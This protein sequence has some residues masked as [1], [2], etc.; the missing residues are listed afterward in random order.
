MWTTVARSGWAA[1]A[2]SRLQAAATRGLSRFVGRDSE[3]EQLGRALKQA[4]QGRGQVVAVVGE[5]GVGK[6]RLFH[7]FVHSHR[8]T[9]WLVLLASSVSYGR[10]TSYLPVVDLLK[11]YFEVEDGDCRS[12]TAYP[13]LAGGS[14]AI[15]NNGANAIVCSSQTARRWHSGRHR[16]RRER[17]QRPRSRC[18]RSWAPISPIACAR[19]TRSG[20]R[21][22]RDKCESLARHSNF[23]HGAADRPE[24]DGGALNER[25]TLSV[26]PHD[27]DTRGVGRDIESTLLE[28]LECRLVIEHDQLLI[29][30]STD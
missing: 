29:G 2:R 30:L 5:L 20:P 7:E 4:Q 25:D 26:A 19:S 1:A 8:T 18:F 13:I 23:H 15:K 9:G 16:R 17:Q 27:Q 11:S 6:S 28:P 22:P 21:S 3:M 10:A 24:E 14:S 12:R